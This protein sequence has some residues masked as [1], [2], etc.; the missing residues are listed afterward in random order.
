[1]LTKEQKHGLSALTHKSD[2]I[3]KSIIGVEGLK[4]AAF[5]FVD[6]FTSGMVTE[7]KHAFE[8]KQCKDTKSM[9]A[10]VAVDLV[11]GIKGLFKKLKQIHKIFKSEYRTELRKAFR[12]Y[13]VALGKAVKEIGRWLYKCPGTKQLAA[14]AAII[15]AG[16]AAMAI[17]GVGIIIAFL[18]KLAGL[19]FKA[20]YVIKAVWDIS[21]NAIKA[22]RG[23]CK[24]PCKKIIVEK[25]FGIVGALVELLLPVIQKGS[26]GT[27]DL[28]PIKDLK[29][30]GKEASHGSHGHG[31]MAKIEHLYHQ[32]H[33][34]ETFAHP[35]AGHILHANEANNIK[36]TFN[37][38]RAIEKVAH[39]DKLES[40]D[41]DEN[42]D[43]NENEN[44]DE[45]E[46]HVQNN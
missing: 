36:D 28:N 29:K 16:M 45:G 10:A 40:D 26:K 27:K 19:Y 42:E 37:A 4:S 39:G 1:V 38:A 31:F 20:K 25:F 7:I 18:G 46:A 41:N 12:N 21:E 22:A 9:K 43:E 23:K 33:V 6:G 8:S 32:V 24:L 17:P 34:G 15:V 2:T 5:G 44:E 13:L 11:K 35:A 30:L 3:E 14:I